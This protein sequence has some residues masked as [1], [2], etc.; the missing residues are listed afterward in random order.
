MGGGYIFQITPQK[1][2]CC[3]AE[4]HS[5][6]Y[7]AYDDILSAI[8]RPNQSMD[9][10]RGALID[11]DKL[12]QDKALNDKFFALIA[13]ISSVDLSSLD[14][15]SQFALYINAYNALTIKMILEHRTSDGFV[16]SITDIT[17]YF[18]LRRVWKV[19]A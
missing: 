16:D 2:P 10:M 7:S 17:Q 13:N 8:V 14:C 5:F 6:D 9:G 4:C 1:P 3:T 18:G 15:L 11:Y 12:R 19:N